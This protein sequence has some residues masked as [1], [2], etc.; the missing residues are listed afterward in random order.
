MAD[1]IVLKLVKE[2]RE[3]LPRCGVPKLHYMLQDKLR[4]HGIKLGRDGL[5]SMGI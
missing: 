2:I 3:D 1:A 5:E 4:V